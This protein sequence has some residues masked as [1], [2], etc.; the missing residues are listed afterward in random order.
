MK[1]S[2]E[3]NIQNGVR[4]VRE[5]VALGRVE[6]EKKKRIDDTVESNGQMIGVGDILEP[7]V[8]D[9]TVKDRGESFQEGVISFS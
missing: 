9:P 5:R 2:S 1:Q 4:V 3:E 6:P 7:F 8:L